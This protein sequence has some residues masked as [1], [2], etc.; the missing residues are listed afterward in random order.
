MLLHAETIF[1]AKGLVV[2]DNRDQAD[3]VMIIKTGVVEICLVSET[4]VSRFHPTL[5]SKTTHVCI[6]QL[7]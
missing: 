3:R 1:V 7:A 2:A 5:V 4:K 6:M